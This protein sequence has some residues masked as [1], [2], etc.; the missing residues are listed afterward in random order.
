M[1]RP[2]NYEGP[3][4]DPVGALFEFR[5]NVFYNWGKGHAGYDADKAALAAYSFVD[6]A[7]VMGPDSEKPVAFDESNSLAKAFFACN[8]MNGVVPADPWSLVSGL[9]A[10]GYR[11]AAPIAVAPVKADPAASA[12]ERVLADAGA[13]VFRDAVDARIVAGVR[14]RTGRLIDS[15]A[16][17]GGWPVLPAGVAAA[18]TDGDGMPDA[19]ETAHG[20]DPRKVDGAALAKGGSGYTN[21]ELYLAD[22]AEARR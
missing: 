11:Q 9:Q 6:N 13:S 19:W 8:S 1:P 16:Q 3:D 22:I 17:V 4:K 2:G 12:Y 5:S 14:D 18:D 10:P 7:Y 20:L 15:Q 21:L